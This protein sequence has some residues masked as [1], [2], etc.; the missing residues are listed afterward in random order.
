MM[1]LITDEVVETL[2]GGGDASELVLLGAARV[3][4]R[5][6][7]SICCVLIDGNALPNRGRVLRRRHR[8]RLRASRDR[9]LPL[10]A[11]A[12]LSR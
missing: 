4:D 10:R 1:L 3:E 12:R 2:A 8:P 5:S 9:A 6:A 7:Q 11:A